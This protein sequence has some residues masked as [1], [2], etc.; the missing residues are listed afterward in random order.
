M[1]RCAW[2]TAGVCALAFPRAHA[3]PPPA[4]FAYVL[5]ADVFEKTKSKAV[6]RL[7][8]CDR[9]WIILDAVFDR[10]TPW[11]RAD[12][13]AIRRGR[14]GRR[15]LAYLSVGEAEDYRPYWRKEWGGNGRLSASAPA[16]I[17]PENP[18][19]RG[20]YPVKYWRP[21]WQ[22]IILS[23]VDDAMG[24]GFDGLY[25]DIVDGFETFEREGGNYVDD[26]RNPETQ[27]SYRRDMVE[28][29]NRVAA[30]ARAKNPAA[31]IVPQ[32][33][34]QLL[35]HRDFLEGIHAI[36][37]EDLFT[38]GDQL[39]PVSH[40]REVLGHLKAIF[41]AQKPVLLIEY[42]KHG[43]RKDITR[44]RASE[45]GMVWLITDRDLTTLGESGR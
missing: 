28:W 43:K 27:R 1:K 31:L 6:E 5:Q 12:L 37:I 2:T 24:R 10:E 44:R 15:V 45:N 17:L 19:W 32:N 9:D 13:D 11:E 7:A 23:A 29:V 30:R 22:R 16:W 35:A 36:G 33:G 14:P 3:D 39:Q 41:E 25:L 4:S 38:E 42:P 20:N 18:R 8:A 21:E 26:R 34:S 40:T